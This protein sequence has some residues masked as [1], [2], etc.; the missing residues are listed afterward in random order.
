M[1]TNKLPNNYQQDVFSKGIPEFITFGE[2]IARFIMFLLTFLMPLTVRSKRQKTGL[3]IYIIGVIVYFVSWSIL[4]NYPNNSW[5]E[6]ILGFSSPAYTPAI[7]LLGICLIGDS[8]Y[9]K[10]PFRRWPFIAVSVAFLAFHISHTIL[11]Y[12]KVNL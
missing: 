8:F 4:I 7:W 10:I 3:Y 12:Y 5:S 11:V 1:L 2:N 6:S 9:Y